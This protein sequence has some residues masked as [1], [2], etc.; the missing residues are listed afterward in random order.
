LDDNL[1]AAEN[2]AREIGRVLVESTGQTTQAIH[3]QA[4]ALRLAT[5]KERERTT[6]ALRSAYD[7]ATGDMNA[8]FQ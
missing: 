2:R 1:G 6:H 3:Q 7:Q 5:G 4:D 8:L